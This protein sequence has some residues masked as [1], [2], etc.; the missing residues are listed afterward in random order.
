MGWAVYAGNVLLCLG[1]PCFRALASGA[2]A[3]ASM[4][5]DRHGGARFSGRRGDY[6]VPAVIARSS[7][8]SSKSGDATAAL[9]I[10]GISWGLALCVAAA[11]PFLKSV[12]AGAPSLGPVDPGANR[13]LGPRFP[14][15]WCLPY[16]D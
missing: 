6:L 9:Q 10:L 14:P 7:G 3:V 16:G 5:G 15:P 4:P 2:A 1:L 13:T 12:G 8:G 11:W